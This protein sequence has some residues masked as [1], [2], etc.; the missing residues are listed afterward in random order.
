MKNFFSIDISMT[1]V[2]KP[3]GE[4]ELQVTWTTVYLWRRYRK[5]SRSSGE[6]FPSSVISYSRKPMKQW[7]FDEFNVTVVSHGTKWSTRSQK[8]S[9]NGIFVRYLKSVKSNKNTRE[10]QRSYLKF[11][12]SNKNI[13][14]IVIKGENTERNYFDDSNL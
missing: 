13:G 6:R 7:R 1:S 3:M 8:P 5:P 14:K 12:K 2:E 4:I 10:M 11:L 9:M